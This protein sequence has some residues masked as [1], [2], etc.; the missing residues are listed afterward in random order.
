MVRD[1]EK[2][3]KKICFIRRMVGIVGTAKGNLT[4]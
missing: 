2:K 3:K 4:N 1:E